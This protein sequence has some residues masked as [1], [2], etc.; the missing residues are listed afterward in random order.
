MLQSREQLNTKAGESVGCWMRRMSVHEVE[1]MLIEL[2]HPFGEPRNR[3]D[4]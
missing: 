1:E 4:A 3:K 2:P